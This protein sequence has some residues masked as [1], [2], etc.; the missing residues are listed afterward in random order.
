MIKLNYIT[1]DTRRN[2]QYRRR[3]R[4]LDLIDLLGGPRGLLLIIGLFA[5]LM[6]PRHPDWIGGTMLVLGAMILEIIVVTWLRRR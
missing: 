4:L 2:D 6:G 5:M 1:P 3:E